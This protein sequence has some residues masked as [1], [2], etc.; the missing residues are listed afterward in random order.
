[1]ILNALEGKVLPIY[2]NGQNIRDWLYVEDHCKAVDLVINNANPGQKFCIGGNNEVKNIDLIKTICS[3]ID[4]YSIEY[5]FDLNH[6]KSM[7]LIKYVP[8][9]PGHDKRYAIDSSKI[10]KELKWKPEVNFKE[11]LIKTITWYLK[12]KNW[13]EPLVNK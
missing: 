7:E 10:Q 11:G 12:N 3:L 8:D 4:K 6:D 5:Y 2:G 13:W 9:R 1:M